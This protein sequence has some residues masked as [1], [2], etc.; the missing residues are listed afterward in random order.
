MFSGTITIALS[1]HPILP[2]E[3][4]VSGVVSANLSR[5]M[6]KNR[7]PKF[8]LT[9]KLPTISSLSP[10][11][12]FSKIL[13]D[14]ESSSS[15]MLL[16]SSQFLTISKKRLKTNKKKKLLHRIFEIF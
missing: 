13:K 11:K 12:D 15:R 1:F 4:T 9:S 7:M 3:E 2:M 8:S 5:G 10:K 14:L 6:L 16:K